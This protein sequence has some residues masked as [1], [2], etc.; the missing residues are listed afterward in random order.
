[1]AM[2]YAAEPKWGVRMK[3]RTVLSEL[4][5]T[6]YVTGSDVHLDRD[7]I[8]FPAAPDEDSISE[9][10]VLAPEGASEP[11]PNFA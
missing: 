9:L 6:D 2:D 10:L 7:V 8:V 5:I 11:A 3:L 1:M 4:G